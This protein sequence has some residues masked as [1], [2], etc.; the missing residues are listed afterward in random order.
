MGELTR[1]NQPPPVTAQNL[2]AVHALLAEHASPRLRHLAFMLLARLGGVAPTLFREREDDDL[3]IGAYGA[4]P[5]GPLSLS[6]PRPHTFV[7]A[8]ASRH[9]HTCT[10]ACPRPFRALHAHKRARA[11]TRT[12]RFVPASACICPGNFLLKT[13]LSGE[14]FFGDWTLRG[15]YLEGPGG[16]KSGQVQLREGGDAWQARRR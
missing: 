6:L 15:S 7:P 10:H 2:A 4:P 5:L 14:L 1:A 16:R 8:C 9:V 11:R 13:G 12:Q 3:H